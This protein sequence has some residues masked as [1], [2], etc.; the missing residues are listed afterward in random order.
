MGISR[1]LQFAGH[2][3]GSG[4]SAVELSH[5][6]P[7]FVRKDQKNKRQLNKLCSVSRYSQSGMTSLRRWPL[8]SKDPVEAREGPKRM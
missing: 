8:S 6:I 3:Q 2:N 1:S 7:A 5:K 4:N